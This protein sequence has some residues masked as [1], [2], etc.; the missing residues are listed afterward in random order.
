MQD[1]G[2]TFQDWGVAIIKPRNIK[3]AE[4]RSWGIGPIFQ[5]G[6]LATAPSPQHTLLSAGETYL[7]SGNPL[8]TNK[9]H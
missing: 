3:M 2:I 6:K 5:Y 9:I 8:M 7:V 1:W 4:R